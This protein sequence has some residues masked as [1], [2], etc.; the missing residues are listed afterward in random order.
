MHTHTLRRA[1]TSMY[2]SVGNCVFSFLEAMLT[3]EQQHIADATAALKQCMA[4][5]QR[6]RRKTT[7][8]ETIGK[9]FRRTNYDAYT[10]V[11]AHAELCLAEALLLKAMLT[12][13]EDETLS[14]LIRGGM[15]IRT[16]FFSFK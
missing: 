1:N 13:V 10:E 6:H 2:H 11:E 5:C 4:V 3:F 15:K 16:C 12:F 9:P 14:S 8:T 7:L